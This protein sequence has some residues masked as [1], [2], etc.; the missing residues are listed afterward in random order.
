MLLFL[1]L[2]ALRVLAQSLKIALR[3]IPCLEI[4]YARR[5]LADNKDR[6]YW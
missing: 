6:A 4:L 5:R 3:T 2:S 1:A